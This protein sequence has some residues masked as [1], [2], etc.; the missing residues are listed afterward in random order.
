MKK[1]DTRYVIIR[2]EDWSDCGQRH[3]TCS[4][5]YSLVKQKFVKVL[6]WKWWKYDD[7]LASSSD[8]DKI[9]EFAKFKEIK[10]TEI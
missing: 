3:I 5:S 1:G 2:E 4:V 6:H 7:V 8:L 10:I 9:K